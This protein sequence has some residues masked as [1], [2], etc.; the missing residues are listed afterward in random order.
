MI[1]SLLFPRLHELVHTVGDESPERDK[2]LW[3]AAV[4]L[5]ELAKQDL[6]RRNQ[7]FII[8]SALGR[9]EMSLQRE[10]DARPPASEEA[11]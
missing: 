3:S 5:D 9:M 10:A 1:S 4:T 7:L 6:G 11:A 8:Q 2:A